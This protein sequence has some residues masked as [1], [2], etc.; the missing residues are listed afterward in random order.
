MTKTAAE[1]GMRFGLMKGFLDERTRRLFAAS[2]AKVMGRG[3]VSAVAR[4][5][6]VSRRAVAAHVR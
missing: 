3:G 6:G 5:T 4:A 1:A 2:E